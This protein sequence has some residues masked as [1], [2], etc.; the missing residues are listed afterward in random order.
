MSLGLDIGYFKSKVVS[1]SKKGDAVSAIK[2]G[3]ANSFND[4]NTFDPEMVTKAQW[5]AN[6]QDLLKATKLRPRSQ[7]NLISSLIH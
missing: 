3:S 6:I 1:L 5:V 4:L 2:A 7:K